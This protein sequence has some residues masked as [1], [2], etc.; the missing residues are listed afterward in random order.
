MYKLFFRTIWIIS[1]LWF[2]NFIF[3]QGLS[4]IFPSWKVFIYSIYYSNINSIV[5]PARYLTD[6][7]TNSVSSGLFEFILAGKHPSFAIKFYIPLIIF[8]LA[9]PCSSFKNKCWY[10]VTGILIIYLLKIILMICLA[11][12]LKYNL[13]YKFIH[14]F[15]YIGT[16][17]LAFFFLLYFWIKKFID[18]KKIY[19]IIEKE[20]KLNN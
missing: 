8:V 11:I 15:V 20:K 18:R 5:I 10:I 9:L 14:D 4:A 6:L 1:G 16:L 19:Q 13:C 17:Y 7:I 3:F 12:S 2:V